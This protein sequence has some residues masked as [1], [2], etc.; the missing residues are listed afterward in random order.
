MQK[1]QRVSAI[2]ADAWTLYADAIEALELGKHRIAAE[3]AW[4]A[5]KRATDALI[6]ARTG[7]EP[8]S[9]GQTSGGIRASTY[10]ESRIHNLAIS[11]PN[12]GQCFHYQ[13][14]YRH[15]QCFYREECADPVVLA[16]LI[17]GPSFYIRQAE[18]L[19]SA[20][21]QGGIC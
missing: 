21:V 11:F 9:T 10:T 17:R 18:T 1:P 7:R 13:R 4:G 12:S 3:V 5:A 8:N 20:Q 2:F 6:L 14:F 15:Y 16:L 19:A